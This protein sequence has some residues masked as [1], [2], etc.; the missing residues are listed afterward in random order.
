MS[1]SF[2]QRY[3][4]ARARRNGKALAKT[5]RRAE[6]EMRQAEYDSLSTGKK[7][8]RLANAP[9]QSKKQ[10]AKLYAQSE[11]ELDKELQM[12]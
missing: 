11:Q 6:A 12:K 10:R 2:E 7:L 9:G 3:G 4:H 8:E 5:Q 1:K